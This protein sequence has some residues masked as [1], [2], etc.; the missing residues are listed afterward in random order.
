MK[1]NITI[2]IPIE[3]KEEINKKVEKGKQSGFIAECVKK[4]LKKI[5]GDEKW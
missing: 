2:S 4:E 5:R 3:L 1:T